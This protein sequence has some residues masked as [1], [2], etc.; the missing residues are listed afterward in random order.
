MFFSNNNNQFAEFIQWDDIGERFVMSNHFFAQG[1]VDSNGGFNIFPEGFVTIDVA[2]IDSLDAGMR[3]HRD[4][5]MEKD[6]DNDNPGAGGAWFQVFTA[7]NTIEQMRVQGG[8]EASTLFD[9]TATSNG[10][11]YAEAFKVADESIA[12]GDVVSLT[13]GQWEHVERAARGY[14][15]LIVGVVSTKPAFLAG[16]SFDQEEAIDPALAAQRSAARAAGNDALER[17]LTEQLIAKVKQAYR[18]VALVGRVPCK[19]DAQYGAI[20]AGDRLTA[21]PTPG[22]AMLQTQPG[23]SLGIALEDHDAGAG[24]ILVF[25]QPGW[26]GVEAVEGG[27]DA[28]G[29]AGDIARA[30]LDDADLANMRETLEAQQTMIDALR[31]EIEALKKA[32]AGQRP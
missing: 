27:G 4:I 10:I 6:F 9:G 14:E 21:S 3:S 24:A 32:G 15:S 22:H 31:Q 1:P 8:D 2:D 26:H 29:P 12:A 7:G 30:L 19:V 11:D 28:R 17:Q 25:V 23:P 18:P 20:R 16:M 5:R 13:P